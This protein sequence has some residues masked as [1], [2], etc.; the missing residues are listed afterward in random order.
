[1]HCGTNR[2]TPR[3]CAVL[4]TYHLPQPHGCYFSLQCPSVCPA[5]RS[6]SRQRS[7]PSSSALLFPLRKKI[8]Q[9]GKEIG[10]QYYKNSL[11]RA[12]PSTYSIITA[13]L[14]LFFEQL[15][16]SCSTP[17]WLLLFKPFP[18][19]GTNYITDQDRSSTCFTIRRLVAAPLM[20][21]CSIRS[22]FSSF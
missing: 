3:V 18:L 8:N 13:F 17:S 6:S 1:M 14:F 16:A 5:V 9:K 15:Y 4:G 7:L 21:L 20:L 19:V 12:V 10:A 22:A 2:G 11:H